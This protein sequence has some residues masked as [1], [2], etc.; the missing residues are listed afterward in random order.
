[1]VRVMFKPFGKRNELMFFLKSAKM[2]CYRDNIQAT[3]VKVEL[4]GV[5]LGLSGARI[6]RFTL[7]KLYFFLQ[8]VRVHEALHCFSISP[9][10]SETISPRMIHFE[11]HSHFVSMNTILTGTTIIIATFAT[12]FPHCPVSFSS[13]TASPLFCDSAIDAWCS[14]VSG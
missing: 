3:K 13:C 11:G 4:T 9:K 8:G 14:F 5:N 1:M 12:C 10:N 2:A 7:K 6:A